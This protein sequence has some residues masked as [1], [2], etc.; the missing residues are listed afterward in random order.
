M[1]NANIKGE[2]AGT[3]LR[4]IM[5]RMIKP[6]KEAAAALDQLGVSATNA[7]GTVKPF[8]EQLIALRN[9][10]KGLTEAQ[11]LKWQTLLQGKKLCLVSWRLLM[12][13]T[14]T[15]QK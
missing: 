3:A 1:A 5:T 14:K 15:S 10:M 13:E 9:A 7:D 12:Q 4:S 6:P 11:K 8:R 2:M